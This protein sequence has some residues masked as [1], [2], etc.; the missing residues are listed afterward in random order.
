VIEGKRIAV[1]LP[2]YNAER[3]LEQTVSE[4]P[5]L[6]D[7]TILVDDHSSDETVRLA[8]TLGLH[9]LVHDCNR[10]YGRNQKTCYAAALERGAD[11]VVMVH[12]DYQYTPR[13]VV[14]MA[15]MIAYG[16]YDVVLG[17]RILV[18]G[19][20]R[21]GM[22]LYKYC[23]NR[24]LTAFQNL[25]L[26]AS[27]SEYHTGFRA[28]A[29]EVLQSLPLARFSDNFLFDNQILAESFLL[30][31][32]IG[33]VSCPTRYFDE[34]SSIGFFRSCEYGLGVL[35]TAFSCSARKAFGT[36]PT[37]LGYSPAVSRSPGQESVSDKVTPSQS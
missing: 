22:P 24:L 21:G 35:K 33:E 2:A 18:G 25:L 37:R 36:A 1:V 29:K 27:L 32:R 13:L 3:T 7:D 9:V 28:Y 4:L 19:A 15:S 23:S 26:G 30:G 5:D 16:V 17:S 8:R 11:I 34:A 14:P 20:L 12:P 31:A 10:G 6:I